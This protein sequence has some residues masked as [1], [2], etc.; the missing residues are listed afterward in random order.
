[1]VKAI[2]V[3]L[4]HKN[5]ILLITQ[6]ELE[7]QML[8]ASYLPIRGGSRKAMAKNSTPRASVKTKMYAT[9][10]MSKF[11]QIPVYYQSISL[12]T[13]LVQLGFFYYKN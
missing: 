4:S 11:P 2:P 12:D 1:M 6:L 5:D 7:N 9:L 13:V 3:Q 10:S 8:L